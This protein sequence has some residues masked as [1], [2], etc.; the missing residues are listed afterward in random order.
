VQTPENAILSETGSFGKK[1]YD[2]AN[3][4][5]SSQLLLNIF[6]EWFQKWEL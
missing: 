1:F 3:R 5:I 6:A 2:V 4:E